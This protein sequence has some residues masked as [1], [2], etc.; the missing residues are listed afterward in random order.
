[1]DA[2]SLN[3]RFVQPFVDVQDLAFEKLE[4]NVKRGARVEVV[5]VDPLDP[6]YTPVNQIIV[7]PPPY[8]IHWV[9]VWVDDFRLVNT[10]LDFGQTHTAYEVSLDGV[11]TLTTPVTEGTIKVICDG[12]F[13]YVM[14]EYTIYVSNE[15]GAKTKNTVAGQVLASYFCEPVIL[16]MPVKGYVRLSDNRRDL[17]Y[18]PPEGFEGYDA[19]SYA[20]YT[21]R[22]QLSEPKCIYITVGKPAKEEPTDG[23][24][25]TDG[26][27]PSPTPTT[28][29]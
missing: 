14:D 17:I 11:V 2:Q 25:P 4:S 22:G 16:S 24:T 19:F 6:N 1:M 12:P 23:D 7:N 10:S 28:G 13:N 9:E 3:C 5:N 21:D 8:N 18:V 20:V 29:G 27:T 26:S 15:Q